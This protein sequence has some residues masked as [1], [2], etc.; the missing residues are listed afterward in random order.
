MCG[1]EK[2]QKEQCVWVGFALPVRLPL[3]ARHRWVIYT[4]SVYLFKKYFG[5]CFEHLHVTSSRRWA[6]F[7][8][9]PDL[10]KSILKAL[11]VGLKP[12]HKVLYLP[13]FHIVALPRLRHH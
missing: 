13:P 9:I 2:T 12:T 4:L 8:I 7:T 11:A 10:P 3:L 6:G 1:S 5:G